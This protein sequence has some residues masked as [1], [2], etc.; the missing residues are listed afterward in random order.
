MAP[1]KQESR[2]RKRSHPTIKAKTSAHK[3]KKNQDGVPAETDICRESDKKLVENS[4]NIT[5]DEYDD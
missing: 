4:V 2:D 1:G 3:P 5:R